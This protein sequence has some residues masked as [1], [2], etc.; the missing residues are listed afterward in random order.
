MLML[1]TYKKDLLKKSKT[2]PQISKFTILVMKH[3]LK[4]CT[5]HNVTR[6][7]ELKLKG[8]QLKNE[9]RKTLFYNVTECGINFLYMHE[10][11]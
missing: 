2:C 10:S 9:M 4:Y 8:K 3:C 11:V 6:N 1:I 7:D 5:W